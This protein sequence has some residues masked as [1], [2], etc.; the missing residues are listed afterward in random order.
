MNSMVQFFEEPTNLAIAAGCATLAGYAANW[1]RI[2]KRA[3]L[4]F[5]TDIEKRAN[6]I[7]FPEYKVRLV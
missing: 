2:P 7:S 3:S 4:E 6:A 1:M 5:P